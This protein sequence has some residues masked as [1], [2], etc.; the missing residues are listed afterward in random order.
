MTTLGDTKDI[1][2]T[3]K[4]DAAD[5]PAAGAEHVVMQPPLTTPT[6]PPQPPTPMRVDDDDVGRADGPRVS[7]PRQPGWPRPCCCWCCVLLALTLTLPKCVLLCGVSVVFSQF[8]RFLARFSG[9]SKS[10]TISTFCLGVRDECQ[11]FWRRD[12][13]PAGD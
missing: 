5:G 2:R 1:T 3:T 7:P 8:Y 11:A 13:A 9:E 10:R 12:F 4:A 6:T